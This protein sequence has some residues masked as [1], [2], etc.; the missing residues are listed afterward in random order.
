MRLGR[1]AF[2]VPP[3]SLHKRSPLGSFMEAG[4]PHMSDEGV[5]SCKR[6]PYGETRL[7]DLTLER[8]LIEADEDEESGSIGGTEQFAKFCYKSRT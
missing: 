3:Q 4:D 6:A 7:D 2:L 8:S 5:R 1:R